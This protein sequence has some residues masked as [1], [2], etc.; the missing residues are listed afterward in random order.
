MQLIAER[1]AQEYNQRKGRH[2]TFGKTLSCH[3]NRGRRAHGSVLVYIDLKT[4]LTQVRPEAPLRSRWLNYRQ[5]KVLCDNSEV[6][7]FME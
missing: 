5:G 1:T 2:G 6:R 4:I 7:V 3:G